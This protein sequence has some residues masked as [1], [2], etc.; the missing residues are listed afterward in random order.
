MTNKFNEFYQTINS[1]S[2]INN[3]QSDDE[4]EFNPSNPSLDDPSQIQDSR[5][6]L[7]KQDD[8]EASSLFSEEFNFCEDLDF[9]SVK[10][11]GKDNV[12]YADEKSIQ[13]DDETSSLF[14]EE[15][16]FCEDL[17]FLSVK[18]KGKDNVVYADEKSIQ[19]DDETSSLFSEE[20]NFC[21]DLDF[22]SG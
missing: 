2:T 3:D 6:Y 22:S 17:D 18:N 20:F 21:V 19:N 15:F 13:D 5:Y 9:L 8:D 1:P 7:K 11:K 12:V 14:S 4:S 16:N 10:N